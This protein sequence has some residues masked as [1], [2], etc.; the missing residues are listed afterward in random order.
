[1][2]IKE[3][4]AMPVSEAEN[5]VA[6]LRAELAKERAVAAG[7]TRPENPGRIRAV[8]KTI[9]RLLTVINE[10]KRA[11]EISG[12]KKALAVGAGA[13]QAEKKAP[14]VHVAKKA[15]VV[16]KKAEK[17]REKKGVKRA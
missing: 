4:R 3:I 6:A 7:G 5:Q 1:M 14:V 16:V 15:G 9:A 12:G 8:R 13:K 10:K 17:G 11:G 2:K